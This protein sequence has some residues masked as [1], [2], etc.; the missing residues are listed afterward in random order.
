MELTRRGFIG[1][2]IAASSLALIG[3]TDKVKAGLIGDTYYMTEFEGLTGLHAPSWAK[4]VM[5]SNTVIA[6]SAFVGTCVDIPAGTKNAVII[7]CS[8]DMIGSNP[9]TAAVT[10]TVRA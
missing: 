5:A 2:L 7:N 10:F 3:A 6:G 9:D 4:I 8:F 1:A